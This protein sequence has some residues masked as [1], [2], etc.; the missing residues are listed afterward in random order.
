[1]GLMDKAKEMLGSEETTDKIL[2]KAEQL[3]TE[4][5]GADKADQIKKV[6]DAVDDKVGE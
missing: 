1:M 2:D 4:K 6:R 5:L 3:A